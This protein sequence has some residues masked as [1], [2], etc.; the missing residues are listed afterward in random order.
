MTGV[1]R[2]ALPISLYEKHTKKIEKLADGGKYDKFY[3]V[4]QTYLVK[5]NIVY[6]IAGKH[7][8]MNI[9]KA[10]KEL[11]SSFMR[12]NKLK[13]SRTNPESYIPALKYLDTIL[14]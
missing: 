1:L 11:V 13:I 8:L 12:K 4:D 3:Q 14:Q 9:L 10:E 5:D 7:D 6:P 2:C